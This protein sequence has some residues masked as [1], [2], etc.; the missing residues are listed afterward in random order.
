MPATSANAKTTFGKL[1]YF[2]ILL[3]PSAVAGASAAAP[4]TLQ[5]SCDV[6]PSPHQNYDLGSSRNVVNGKKNRNKKK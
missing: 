5:W 1:K 4:A 2:W 6:V 3:D